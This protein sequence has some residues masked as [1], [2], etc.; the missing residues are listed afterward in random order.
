MKTT[1]RS[2]GKIPKT[3]RRSSV[4]NGLITSAKNVSIFL[5][6]AS[7]FLHCGNDKDKAFSEKLGLLAQSATA[8]DLFRTQNTPRLNVLLRDQNTASNSQMIHSSSSTSPA[9][10]NELLE[11]IY[12]AGIDIRAF[13]FL[14][15]SSNTGSTN[16]TEEWD[17]WEI[18]PSYPY[19]SLESSDNVLLKG[20][21][22]SPNWI[23]SEQ[24]V[25][26][27]D[28]FELDVIS[29]NLQE[30]GIVYDNAFYSHA[31]FANG[32]YH[33]LRKPLYKYPQW[34]EIPNHN[35]S[36][37]YPVLPPRT[38]PI[39]GGGS[40]TYSTDTPQ[41]TVLFVRRDLLSSPVSLEV[42]FNHTI[43][44]FDSIFRSSRTLTDQEER[45]ILSLYRQ[46]YLPNARI[47]VYLF[48]WVVLIPFDAPINVSVKGVTNE[49]TQTYSWKDLD[50]SVNMDLSNAID[51]TRSDLGL[52]QPSNVYFNVDQNK[53][54]FGLNLNVS[55]KNSQNGN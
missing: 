8:I 27:R 32:E 5:L 7:A 38:D 22:V 54:P 9:L 40:I 25:P 35:V 3:F 26:T 49:N 33:T 43:G 50:I 2:D 11:G 20:S 19:R 47:P 48:P 17:Y 4:L 46:M 21:S 31:E 16:E 44:N 41:V 24:H 23:P 39:P 30:S 18:L 53:V 37:L 36:N 14:P 1:N 6:L 10:S 12:F 15:Q 34:S 42:K 52:F 28:V 55:K 45:L 51:T 29:V 13:D